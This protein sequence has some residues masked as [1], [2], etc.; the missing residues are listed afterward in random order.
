MSEKKGGRKQASDVM[1]A[2]LDNFVYVVIDHT[3][4]DPMRDDVVWTYL[5]QQEIADEL[6]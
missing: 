4:G 1:P 5:T 6:A 2:L 3:A